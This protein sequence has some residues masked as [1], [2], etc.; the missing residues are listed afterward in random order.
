M[1]RTV[2][3]SDSLNGKVIVITGAASDFGRGAALAF[4]RAGAVLV[5]AARRSEVL[6]EVTRSCIAEARQRHG[7]GNGRLG[8]G[9]RRPARP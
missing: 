9:R 1:S 2:P 4:A 7:G 3:A 5:L 8:S 6:D